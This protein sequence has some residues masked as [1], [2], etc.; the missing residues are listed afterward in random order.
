MA[1]FTAAGAVAPSTRA[2]RSQTARK[3]QE[4]AA[5]QQEQQERQER[6]EQQL[7]DSA[8][9]SEGSEDERGA[10]EKCSSLKSSLMSYLAQT[11]WKFAT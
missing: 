2:T 6:Q 3:R 8:A 5:K 10:R 4:Q 9:D 7:L 11:D 1:R